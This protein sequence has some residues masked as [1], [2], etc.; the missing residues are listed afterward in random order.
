MAM[1]ENGHWE[2]IMEQFRK[3]AAQDGVHDPTGIIARQR[4]TNEKVELSRLLRRQMT[5]AECVL[6]DAVRGKRLAGLRFRRQQVIDGFVV[7]FYCHTARLV[8]EVDGRI[9]E[10]QRGHDIARDQILAGRAL[11]VIR[12]T[13]DDVLNNLQDVLRRIVIAAESLPGPV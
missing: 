3:G 2:C 1:G 7:D 12:F 6:W 13:N 4:V 5:P 11:R 9:H 8:V 10:T